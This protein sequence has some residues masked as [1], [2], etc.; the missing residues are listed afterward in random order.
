MPTEGRELYFQLGMYADGAGD[1]ALKLLAAK[2]YI[3]PFN[4]GVLVIL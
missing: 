3:L 4:S 2:N 1:D